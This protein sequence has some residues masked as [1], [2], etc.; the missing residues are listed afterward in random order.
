[1]V[2]LHTGSDEQLVYVETES[3]TVTIKGSQFH[4][5]LA[6]VATSDK[7]ASL[8]I[9]CDENIDTVALSG[10]AEKV[11]F[12]THGSTVAAGFR[13]RPLFYEQQN[14]ELIIEVKEDG[15]TA[16][17]WHENYN[18]R[19]VVTP[20][21]K[22]NKLLTGVIN[23]HSEIGFS[24]LVVRLD[25]VDYL[26]LRIE[27]FPTKINYKDDYK[28]IVAD[29]TSEVY[30]LVFDFMKKTYTSLD[31]SSSQQ[32]SQVEFF[33]IA[34]GLQALQTAETMVRMARSVRVDNDAVIAEYSGRQTID[35]SRKRLELFQNIVPENG[36]IE[37]LFEGYGSYAGQADGE[38]FGDNYTDDTVGNEDLDFSQGDEQL[39]GYDAAASG[40]ES[41]S[42][43]QNTAPEENWGDAGD[44]EETL[45]PETE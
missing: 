27:V 41:S 36:V 2:L 9:E 12:E 34:S 6:G 26:T 16:Q 39:D 5:A 38:Y 25:G 4:P 22:Q 45:P 37:E 29:V 10:D 31:I 8:R 23:F 42:D 35:Y 19:K 3:L 40:T 43:E 24:D 20:V 33:A 28:A 14:Y 1:M 18:V 17:F 15:H 21:G 44:T 32:S 13:S 7:E 11:D 30:S